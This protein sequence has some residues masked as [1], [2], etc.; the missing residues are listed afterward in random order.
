MFDSCGTNNS[1]KARE[2]YESDPVSKKVDDQ[3]NKDIKEVHDTTR[4]SFD[5]LRKWFY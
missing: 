4:F 3:Q 2:G 1:Q 5:K